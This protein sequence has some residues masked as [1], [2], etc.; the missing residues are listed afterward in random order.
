MAVL[1][2]E[3]DSVGIREFGTKVNVPNHPIAKLMYYLGCVKT[4][5]PTLDKL[6]ERLTLEQHYYNLTEDEKDAVV[7]LAALLN[8]SELLGKVI[9]PVATGSP[10]L[11]GF[12]NTFFEVTD[13]KTLQALGTDGDVAVVIEGKRVE[14]LKFMVCQESWIRNNWLEP[15]KS[16]SGR[17]ARLGRSDSVRE[18]P[19]RN[20]NGGYSGGGG[21]G[22]GG[23]YSGYSGGGG[24]S[25]G[26]SGGGYRPLEGSNLVKIWREALSVTVILILYMVA[27]TSASWASGGIGNT[28][29]NYGLWSYCVSSSSECYSISSDSSCQLLPFLQP[30]F[31]D[32][33]DC[34]K[35][36]AT[37]AMMVL[38]TMAAWIMW[39]LMALFV[40]IRR[41]DIRLTGMWVLLTTVLGLIAMALFA[42]VN[43]TAGFQA[44]GVTASTGLVTCVI[45]WLIGLFTFWGIARR[46]DLLNSRSEG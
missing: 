15:M 25:A 33:N 4:C 28:Q 2:R 20:Y 38:G 40:C 18:P 34:S 39:L 42:S 36:V 6:P 43:Q 21:G 46:A 12:G 7:V 22:G 17:V 1:I 23:G 14:V 32:Q 11:H 29:V 41:P 45:G 24:Y 35:F 30:M 27:I 16:E 5:L 9:F 44:N 8:P 26:Y 3:R 31:S 13:R 19:P 10:I 37:R